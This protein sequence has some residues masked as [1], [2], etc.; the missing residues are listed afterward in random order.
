LPKA[1][2]AGFATAENQLARY[3]A[4]VA[5]DWKSFISFCRCK[6]NSVIETAD[7][8]GSKHR[9]GEDHEDQQER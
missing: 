6:E 9:Q 4:A 2:F 3:G 5:T 1:D 8:S 7:T